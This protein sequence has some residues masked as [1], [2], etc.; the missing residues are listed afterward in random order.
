[1]DIPIEVFTENILPLC[2]V[3]DVISLGCANKFFVL[4]ANDETY[5]K[6][7]LAIDY[8]FTGLEMGRMSGWRFLYWRFRNP[9]IFIWRY[10]TPPTLP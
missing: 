10:V 6:R 4:V 2:E 5:W 7:K 8:N 1:M 9:Q 3:E